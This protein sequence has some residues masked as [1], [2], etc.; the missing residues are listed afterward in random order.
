MRILIEDRNIL[1]RDTSADID[2]PSDSEIHGAKPVFGEG[3][4][5]FI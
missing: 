4:L 3:L 5:A 2:T 1:F